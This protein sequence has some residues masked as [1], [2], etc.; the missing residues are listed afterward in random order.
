MVLTNKFAVNMQKRYR[1]VE[2]A[3]L[4]GKSRQWCND[5]IRRHI[6]FNG[7]K[8]PIHFTTIDERPIKA[9]IVYERGFAAMLEI[10]EPEKK[11]KKK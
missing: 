9:M 10:I 6:K 8:E 2:F 7:E 3:R 5:K 11:G 1:Q 4:I